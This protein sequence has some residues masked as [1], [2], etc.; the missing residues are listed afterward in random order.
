MPT[1]DNN[2]SPYACHNCKRGRGQWCVKCRRVDQD[3]QRIQ[4]RPSFSENN[5]RPA[6]PNKPSERA[7]SLP[8]DVEDTLRI[9]MC[10]LFD[11]KPLELLLVQH[12]VHGRPLSTFGEA[13]EQVRKKISKYRGSEKAQA[14]AMKESVA[15][16][17]KPLTALVDVAAPKAKQGKMDEPMDDL[18]GFAGV[19][20]GEDRPTDRKRKK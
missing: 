20:I 1:K 19:E 3:D 6:F 14:H 15:R 13:I 4:R 9:A 12:I 8:V 7:T 5:T 10:G 11:L 2:Y 17:W 18:F 16:K